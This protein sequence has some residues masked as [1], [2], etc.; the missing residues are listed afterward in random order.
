MFMC[1]SVNKVNFAA[2]SS[3]I[4]QSEIE[5]LEIMELISS[6]IGQT[7]IRAS[8]TMVT[9]VAESDLD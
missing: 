6:I 2:V 5:L 8:D 1:K 7:R 9:K 3:V 4:S